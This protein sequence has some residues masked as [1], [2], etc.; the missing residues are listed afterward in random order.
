[1]GSG[2]QLGWFMGTDLMS[3][4]HAISSLE[5]C[6]IIT[7]LFRNITSLL[8]KPSSS[9]ALSVKENNGLSSVSLCI[10]GFNIGVF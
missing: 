1:M 8:K 7:M 10:E 4:L 3:V 6:W 2:G 9:D 5:S